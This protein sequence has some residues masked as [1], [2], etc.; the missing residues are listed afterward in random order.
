MNKI[1]SIRV[2]N[3][4]NPMPDLAFS[5]TVL[6]NIYI[7]WFENHNYHCFHCIGAFVKVSVYDL[8][9]HNTFSCYYMF[10]N[11]HRTS[12]LRTHNPTHFRTTVLAFLNFTSL[13]F[14]V[15][16]Q[17]NYWRR[18]YLQDQKSE[19]S[20]HTY[21]R[22]NCVDTKALGNVHKNLHFFD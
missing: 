4:F 9:N 21:L 19:F 8:Y 12:S 17:S 14:D 2:K 6:S 15:H 18:A 20:S 7:G 16:C 5:T 11:I 3:E 1:S 22:H 10:E 13:N